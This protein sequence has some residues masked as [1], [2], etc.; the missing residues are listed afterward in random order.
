MRSS[1]NFSVEVGFRL[2]RRPARVQ[3]GT[4]NGYGHP[5]GQAVSTASWVSTRASLSSVFRHL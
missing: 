4:G 3:S 1:G 2:A 5:G